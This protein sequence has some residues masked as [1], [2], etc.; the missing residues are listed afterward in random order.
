MAYTRMGPVHTGEIFTRTQQRGHACAPAV[1]Y[2]APIG[3]GKERF[4]IKWQILNGQV[5]TGI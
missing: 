2:S 3:G 1:D 4:C 5:N